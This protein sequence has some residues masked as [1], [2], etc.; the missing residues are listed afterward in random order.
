MARVTP[1]FRLT[2]N[3]EEVAEAFE[4]SLPVVMDPARHRREGRE[5]KGVWRTFYAIDADGRYIWG[6]TAGIIRHLY[7][8]LSGEAG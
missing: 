6:A 3:P 7:E 2:L 1:D 4:V 8:C 5:W